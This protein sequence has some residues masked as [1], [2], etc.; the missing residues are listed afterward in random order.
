MTSRQGDL[1]LLE[2]PV[3]QQL[4]QSTIPA[5]LAYTWEDGSPRVVP[6]NFHW[7]EKELVFGT[8]ADAPKMKVLRDGVSVAATIDGESCLTTSSW[9]G[10]G[11]R[12]RGHGHRPRVPDADFDAW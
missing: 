8:P 10:G 11:A 6:I 9:W 5:R 3:A 1:S 12:G 4:L 2:D 7:N